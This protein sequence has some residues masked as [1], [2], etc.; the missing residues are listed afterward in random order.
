MRVL[1]ASAELRDAV[2]LAA[3]AEASRHD[4]RSATRHLRGV[5]Y[6]AA[7]ERHAGESRRMEE[8]ATLGARAIRE[9]VRKEGDAG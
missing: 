4:W 1:L 2:G 9:R 3:R 6:G 5:V 8:A 7:E